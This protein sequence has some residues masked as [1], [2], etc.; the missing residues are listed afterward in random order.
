MKWK[1]KL[2]APRCWCELFVHPFSSMDLPGKMLRNLVSPLRAIT[3][4][5]LSLV[6]LDH[7]ASSHGQVAPM[8]WSFSG[9]RRKGIIGMTKE[10]PL[11][12]AELVNES[13]KVIAAASTARA[14][15]SDFSQNWREYY[16]IIRTDNLLFIN[17][18][19]F[20]NQRK[21]YYNQHT[22]F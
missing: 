13:N 12:L 8:S 7:A 15:P 17:Q 2:L 21:K 11:G 20:Q 22:Y 16:F 19:N 6:S 9:Q 18:R 1:N 4:D 3:H 5:T 10:R 14:S